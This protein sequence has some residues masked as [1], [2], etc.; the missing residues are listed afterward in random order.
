MNLSKSQWFEI[1]GFGLFTAFVLWV[2]YHGKSMV[3]EPSSIETPSVSTASPQPVTFPSLGYPPIRIP[4][5]GGCD[6][7]CSGGQTTPSTIKQIIDQT[8]AVI[9]A[10]QQMVDQTVQSEANIGNQV[11]GVFVHY[12]VTRLN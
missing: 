9:A 10:M 1:A 6:C 2:I 12:D 5:Y 11:G 3:T 4:N 8:N 7:G